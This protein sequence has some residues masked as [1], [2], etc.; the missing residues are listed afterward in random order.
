M[1]PFPSICAGA[2]RI[3][4]DESNGSTHTHQRY[5]RVGGS[6]GVR[7]TV[8]ADV[9]QV[10]ARFCARSRRRGRVVN[11]AEMGCAAAVVVPG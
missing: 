8:V 9:L 4:A 11:Y 10:D 2:A 7:D 5:G 6:E 3:G 1:A